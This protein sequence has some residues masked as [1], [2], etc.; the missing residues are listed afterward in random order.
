MF[1]TDKKISSD[2]RAPLTPPRM[3]NSLPTPPTSHIELSNSTQPPRGTSTNSEHHIRIGEPSSSSPPQT[4]HHPSQSPPP[5]SMGNG[6]E[7]AEASPS[8]VAHHRKVKRISSGAAPHTADESVQTEETTSHQERGRSRQPRQNG[9]AHS[10]SRSRTP[11]PILGS[12]TGGTDG[13]LSFHAALEPTP[14]EV[15]SLLYGDA[16]GEDIARPRSV[17]KE[18][19]NGLMQSLAGMGLDNV[20]EEMQSSGSSVSQERQL[21]SMVKKLIKHAQKQ[22]EYIDHNEEALHNTRLRSIAMLSSLRTTFAHSY[23]AEF[24]LRAR[25]E[26]ELDGV[27]LQARK[28]SQLLNKSESRNEELDRERA[29]SAEEEILWQEEMKDHASAYARQQAARARAAQTVQSTPGNANGSIETPRKD[30]ST[31]YVDVT[32]E[33]ASRPPSSAVQSTPVNVLDE[34]FEERKVNSS[35]GN[36]PQSVSDSSLAGLGISSGAG[37]SATIDAQN[38]PAG[39]PLSTIIKERNKLMADKRYLKSRMRDAEAQRDRL[40]LELKSLR[41]LLVRGVPSKNTVASQLTATP[42]TPGRS[43]KRDRSKRRKQAMM[44]DAEAEHLLLAARRLQKTRSNKEVEENGRPTTPPPTAATNPLAPRTPRTPK[45]AHTPKSS[46][47]LDSVTQSGASSRMAPESVIAPNASPLAG[48]NGSVGRWGSHQRVDSARSIGGIDD[49]LQAAQTVLTPG[50]KLRQQQEQEQRRN[51]ELRGE[52]D[53]GDAAD[54]TARNDTMEDERFPL[55]DNRFAHLDRSLQSSVDESPKRRRV[56]SVAL[57]ADRR[58]SAILS[59]PEKGSFSTLSRRLRT[60]TE[61]ADPHSSQMPN[62]SQA[63]ALS[64][65]DLLAD[66]AA[67]SQQPSQSSEQSH[68]GEGEAFMGG[69]SDDSDDGMHV[70]HMGPNGTPQMGNHYYPRGAYGHPYAHPPPMGHEAYR[71]NTQPGA[72]AYG[73]GGSPVAM[74]SSQGWTSQNIPPGRNGIYSPPAAHHARFALQSGPRISSGFVTNMQDGPRL[75]KA[76]QMM[77]VNMMNGGAVDPGYSDDESVGTTQ[78]TPQKG[79]NTSPDKRLPYVRWSEE[80]DQ[81]LRRAI[82][83]FGQRW[84]SVARVVGSRTY[85]QCRQRYLLMRRKEAAAKEGHNGSGDDLRA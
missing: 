29:M 11:S 65:L 74:S 72:Y 84:E 69:R 20:D 14:E 10:P 34:P 47:M 42:T 37:P 82:K 77:N 70:D 38:A 39:S 51:S 23:A 45:I 75:A 27:K 44:G 9:H 4:V 35:G 78:R 7:D 13:R 56:S 18:E 80:E 83:E 1:A 41:P 25:L 30:A 15:R 46:A 50:E 6:G 59:S 48:R 79:G 54:V 63:S 26:A 66:Q 17:G 28:L 53:E 61:G 67:A 40:E 73:P 58:H 64:A 2:G 32:A 21:A 8:V 81:R 5:S 43:H 62:A 31:S 52:D 22:D 76:N 49:L 19:M 33:N 16:D 24:E 36:L 85:H 60:H 68:S 3:N 71:L 55:Q 57:E 12:V